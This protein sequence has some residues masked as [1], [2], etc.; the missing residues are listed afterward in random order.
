MGNKE[1][2]FESLLVGTKFNRQEIRKSRYYSYQSEAEIAL[3]LNATKR[4]RY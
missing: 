3:S 2:A 4:N 1:T